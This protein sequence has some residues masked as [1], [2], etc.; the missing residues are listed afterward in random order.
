[1]AQIQTVLGPIEDS[2]LGFTLSHEH[3]IVSNGEDSAHYPWLYD[4]PATLAFELLN[5]PHENLTAGK[6][7]AILKDAVA[8]VRRSNPTRTIVV[9][10]VAW[11]GISELKSLELPEADRNLLV[12][13]HYYGPFK[14]THQGAHWLPE[15]SRPPT[16]QKWT[17]S[18]E[19]RD[20]VTREFDVAALWGLKH[21]RPIYLGE[22]GAIQHA[23]LESRARWTKFIAEEAAKRRM[24]SAYWE[25]C[26]GF[27]AYDPQRKEWLAPLRAALVGQ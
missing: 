23:D 12:T 20:A 8:I 19:E 3:V 17:G 9:G 6:W 14:F 2:Q 21:R 10:P 16:G 22:F 4:R 11:N 25:F 13:V 5:E 26:S 24:S 1:M 15:S 18:D 27:G 7:N